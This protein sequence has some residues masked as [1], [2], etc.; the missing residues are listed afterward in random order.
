MTSPTLP[1]AKMHG[2][3]N[4][5]VV[6]DGL[7]HDVGDPSAFAR[8]VCDRR[9]GV[10]SDGLLLALPS[11]RAD[12]R[13][14]MFNPDG[15]EAEMCGNGLRCLVSFAVE[16][17]LVE[18]ATELAIETGAGILGA[19]LVASGEDSDEVAIAM[20]APRLER[21]DVP[22]EGPSGRAIDEPLDVDGTT[23][24]VTAVGMGNPH[25]V[26]FVED[27]DAVA[28][29]QLGP[30]I[31]THAAFPRRTNVEFVQVLA[32]DALRQRTWERGVG[33]T[34]ACGTGACAVGVAAALTGRAERDVTVHLRGGDLRIAWDEAD[35]VRMT[36]PAV[37]VF[38][39]TW[40]LSSEVS[41]GGL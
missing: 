26:V 30:A 39:G 27:V 23:V 4:D 28:L 19:S 36:G 17:G 31:E 11:E 25:A 6:V 10:G 21:A 16:R 14:R 8:E 18:R 12:L 29:E 35:G 22:M 20:G 3:A 34:L 5:Y 7:R 2:C 24:A 37:H 40:P 32:S 33:E 41:D 9:R 13:M 1:F 15:S 38:D